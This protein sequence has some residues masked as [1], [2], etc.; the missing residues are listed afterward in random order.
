MELSELSRT[1]LIAALSATPVV[2]GPISVVLDHTL[3]SKVEEE[4]K[5]TI[6]KLRE[7][8]ETVEA[9]LLKLRL[10]S[11]EFFTIL[12]RVLNFSMLNSRQEKLVAFR[13][14][15]IN[16]VYAEESKFDETTLFLRLTDELTVDQIKILG[17]FYKANVLKDEYLLSL[18]QEKG[19]SLKSLTKFFW[20][21]IDEDYLMACITELM[22]FWLVSGSQ[23][24]KD[25]TSISSNVPTS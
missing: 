18:L 8:L 23:K 5:N 16:E 6:E 15:L 25:R 11:H 4:K 20:K 7:D 22:R 19:Q 2:G 14:I 21:D 1:L 24:N 13:N 12:S 9:E 17:L 3:P 10:E